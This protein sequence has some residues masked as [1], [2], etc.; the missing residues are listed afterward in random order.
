MLHLDILYLRYFRV[1]ELKGKKKKQLTADV[2]IG[3][4]LMI[5][6]LDDGAAH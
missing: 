2:V 6:S 3:L 4:L 5:L 1:R